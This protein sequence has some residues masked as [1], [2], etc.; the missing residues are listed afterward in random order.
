MPATQIAQNLAF[1]NWTVLTGL[2]LGSYAAVVLLRR[3]T[4]ATPGYLRFTTICAVGFGVLAWISDGALPTSLGDSPVV[5]DPAWD[6]P[7]RAALLLFAGLAAAALVARRVDP[8]SPS[9][10]RVGRPRRRAVATLVFGALAWG[11]GSLGA[12]ALLVQLAVVSAA[13]GGV[14]AA[15][16]LGHWYLVTPKL[17]EAPLILLARVLLAVVVVQV[18]LFWAWIGD[19]R[20]PGRRGAV[21]LAGRAVGA[22][23]LAA[24]DRR[25]DLPAGRLLGLGP[26]G[27]DALD[28]VGD[29]TAVHQRRVDRGRDDPGRRALFRCRTTGVRD[30]MSKDDRE[31]DPRTPSTSTASSRSRRRC[32][33]RW[34]RSRRPP[35]RSGIPI[36][37]RDAGRVLSVLAGGRRRIVE[38]G[39]AYGFSTLWLALGQPADG[40]IVTIDPDRERTDL[41]RGWW[42]EAGIADE[43]I[44]VV[45][46]PALEAF[47]TRSGPRRAV[48]HGLHR[49]AQA[50]VR[51][52]PRGARRTGSR[53]ARS[54]PPTTSCGAVASRAPGRPTRTTRTPNALRAFD[55]AVLA[56]PRFNATI[57]PVGDGLLVASLARLTQAAMAIAVRVR[58]FAIQ[59]ELAGARE[60]ALELADGADVEAAWAA[61]V[62]AAPGPG[63]RA[64]PSLR[65]A[66]N[67]DYADPTTRLADGD[68][69][70]MIPPVSGGDDAAEPARDA[71]LELR[72]APFAS[73][74]LAELADALADPRGR[75]GRRLPGPDPLDAR[76]AGPG[77]GGRGRAPRRTER[78]VAR[79]RGP[80]TDGPARR[81]RAIADEIARAVRG[82]APGDRPPDRRGAA[83]R[84]V[85]R[86][87]GRRA[88]SRRGVRGGPLRDRRDEGARPDLEGRAV[89][90]R[91]RLDR[92]P[93]PDRTGGGRDEGLH[94]R[95]H[96]G[97][98]RGQ[99]PGPDRTP[100]TPRYPARST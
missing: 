44:T 22:V 70:A 58:L 87:R 9:R 86:G 12:A 90:R 89:R 91:P 69:V 66:R 3:R 72:E 7:R 88:A 39:T 65:F 34:P 13:T 92:P 68:E 4:T 27:A 25:S 35:S 77:P 73:S 47:G 49:R 96:G 32:R 42:R 94:Q 8:R 15:M 54:S 82:R 50:G 28:G 21:R 63:A 14:F 95:R 85:D 75:R 55:A 26:D 23:R 74:I 48:R 29:R 24:P 64:V 36:V 60:V 17:P 20:G 53:R 76:D 38:V 19:R 31:L 78:R 16:I 59:R 61:L 2:A 1:V 6:A 84:A 98:R 18:V 45:N 10:T 97:D 37:D 43:R 51:R 67:G 93:G 71:I 56:D 11:G 81:W 30:A 52:L 5:V 79:I 100:S 80:R 62:D 46:A 40:T 83:R 57:L 41:A 33:P 99:P